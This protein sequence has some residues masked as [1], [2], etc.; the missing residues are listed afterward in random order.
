MGDVAK[1]VQQQ[2]LVGIK[3]ESVPE[4]RGG[5]RFS[6]PRSDDSYSGATQQ[7]SRF[8]RNPGFQEKNECQVEESFVTQENQVQWNS[9]HHCQ[10][11]SELLGGIVSG[12]LEPERHN[13]EEDC[14][15]GEGGQPA[16]KVRRIDGVVLPQRKQIHEDTQQQQFTKD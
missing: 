2:E 13:S 5:L 14:P 10:K 4:D 8:H 11:L 12:K 16:G 7:S 6:A 1:F 9:Q 15:E 3:K